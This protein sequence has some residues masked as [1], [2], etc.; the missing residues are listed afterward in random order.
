MN[1]F[2]CWFGQCCLSLHTV[3]ATDAVIVT[4]IGR[5]IVIV[6]FVRTRMPVGVAVRLRM[7]VRMRFRF[8]LWLSV[9]THR[10]GVPQHR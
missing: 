6:S 9:V 7:P 10:M 5:L 8:T 1:V 3:I 2:N 4:G